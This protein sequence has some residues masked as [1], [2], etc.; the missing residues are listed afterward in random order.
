MMKVLN[1]EFSI[2]A[3]NDTWSSDIAVDNPLGMY[4]G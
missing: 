2:F 4:I 3:E 1:F